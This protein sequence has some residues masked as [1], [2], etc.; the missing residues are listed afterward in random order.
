M[1]NIKL[2]QYLGIARKANALV[3][4]SDNLKNYAKKLYLLIVA[5]NAG[6][7]V[8]TL[9]KNIES[10]YNIDVVFVEENLS[11]LVNINNCQIV[12]VKNK[13]LAD[14]IKEFCN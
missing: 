13:G 8:K 9:A 7:K 1:E 11:M 4:G 3:I 2:S 10:K 12:G 6:E 5:Q 14:K